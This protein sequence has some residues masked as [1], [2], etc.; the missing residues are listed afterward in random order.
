MYRR[1]VRSRVV[2]GVLLLFACKGDP[3]T[4]AK[5]QPAVSRSAEQPAAAS[6]S[7]LGRRAAVRAAYRLAPDRRFRDAAAAIPLVLGGSSVA[8]AKFEAADD[9]WRLIID[10]K[11]VGRLPDLA[12]FDQALALLTRFAEARLAGAGALTGGSAPPVPMLVGGELVAALRAADA[13]WASGTHAR[14]TV[15]AAAWAL[16]SLALQAHDRYGLGDALS[17]RALA[18]LAVARAGGASSPGLARTEG[19]YNRLER[20]RNQGKSLSL[21][22]AEAR[23]TAPAP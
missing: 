9:A 15:E 14:A 19:L 3:A 6:S 20:W 21:L 10:G 23:S 12:D 8:D 18:T 5:D 17:A 11:E 2:C 16:T 4:P 22:A 13:A 7:V 1:R